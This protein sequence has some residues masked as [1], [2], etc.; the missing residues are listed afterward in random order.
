MEDVP[1]GKNA[2]SETGIDEKPEEVRSKQVDQERGIKRKGE[3]SWE[4]GP[5][6]R[7]KAHTRSD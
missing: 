3:T 4:H 7:K 1:A 2:S 6:G 5:A